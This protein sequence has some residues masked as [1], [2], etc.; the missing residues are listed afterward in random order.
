VVIL[1]LALPD[2]VMG[3]FLKRSAARVPSS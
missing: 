2:G 1:V 3:L